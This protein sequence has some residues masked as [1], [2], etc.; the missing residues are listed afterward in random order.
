MNVAICAVLTPLGMFCF[1]QKVLECYRRG[2]MC[3]EINVAICNCWQWTN[4]LIKSVIEEE[5]NGNRSL[6]LMAWFI[7][8]ST[9]F[10]HSLHKILQ[11]YMMYLIYNS[12]LAS[13]ITLK[14]WCLHRGISTRRAFMLNFKWDEK[15]KY[16]SCMCG[17]C[18]WHHVYWL[19]V[20]SCTDLRWPGDGGDRGRDPPLPPIPPISDP[21][22]THGLPLA[23]GLGH[24]HWDTPTHPL[25]TRATTHSAR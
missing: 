5:L 24:A 4:T 3:Y 22:G 12:L 16:F 9:F 10:H 1:A 15:V 17:R 18:T 8:I 20:L 21:H 14:L 2:L 11:L 19:C 13:F 25:G 6:Y 23:R 7:I